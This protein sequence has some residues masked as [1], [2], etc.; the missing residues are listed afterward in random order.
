[1]E[2]LPPHSTCVVHSLHAKKKPLM[3]KHS[4][5]GAGCSHRPRVTD[6]GE[7][8]M[9]TQTCNKH[10]HPL[11][12]PV[13]TLSRCICS[14]LSAG[15]LAAIQTRCRCPLRGYCCCL[16]LCHLEPKQVHTSG[17]ADTGMPPL[18]T[19]VYS[20]RA[21]SVSAGTLSVSWPNQAAFPSRYWTMSQL[22]GAKTCLLFPSGRWSFMAR[23]HWQA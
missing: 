3:Q 9:R 8:T 11:A 10:D 1:M 5:R 20:R 13:A 7:R 21:N 2:K 12:L 22:Q 18:P 15:C 16:H 19:S 4:A 23:A 14:A 6:R 17:A